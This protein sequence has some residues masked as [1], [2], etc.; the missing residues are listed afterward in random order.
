MAS[1]D[2]STQEL[3][4]W[5]VERSMNLHIGESSVTAEVVVT[6][7]KKFENYVKSA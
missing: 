2:T 3:R 6:D 7:A 1:A 5:A 4:R